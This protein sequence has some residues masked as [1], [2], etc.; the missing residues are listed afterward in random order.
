MS[1]Y[2]R[3]LLKPGEILRIDGTETLALTC[4]Q[5]ELWL[6]TASGEEHVLRAGDSAACARGRLLLEGSG[7]VLLKSRIRQSRYPFPASRL[8]PY[9]PLTL[10]LSPTV[11]K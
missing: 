4:E 8:S 1:T 11:H 3:L 10:A 9:T 6:S 2:A 7:S 5:G